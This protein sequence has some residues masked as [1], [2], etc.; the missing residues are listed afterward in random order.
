MDDELTSGP[1][2]A[3]QPVGSSAPA[4]RPRLGSEA[5]EDGADEGEADPFSQWSPGE[6]DLIPLLPRGTALFE[7]IPANA[8]VIDALCPAIGQGTVIVRAADCVGVVL[9]KDGTVFEEHAFESGTGLQGE[10][11][12]RAI[13]TWVDAGVAAY[14]LDPLVVAVIPSLFRGSPCYSDLRLEW[15][16]WP[17]LLADLCGRDGSFVVELDTPLGRGV[18]LIVDGRQVATYTESHTDLGPETLLDPLADTRRGTIW[19]RREPSQEAEPA[20]AGPATAAAVEGV[21]PAEPVDLAGTATAGTA[22][23]PEPAAWPAEAAWPAQVAEEL[24][25]TVSDQPPADPAGASGQAE[26]SPFAR[27]A[28]PRTELSAW[29]MPAGDAVHP[30]PPPAFADPSVADLAP[31][32]KQVARNHL[33]RSSSRVETM[34]DEA[35]ARELPLR[36]FLAEIRG[37]VIRGVMQSTLDDMADEM[38]TLASPLPPG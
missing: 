19:V 8:V 1:E 20:G 37:L 18:T 25:P 14:R 35:V 10:A 32:L 13:A 34:V 21:T 15:T 7:G 9:V 24:S 38:A 17:G 16:D 4:G 2:P 5:E 28:A 30:G 36:S 11:A 33:Q 26:E 3:E 27:F 22:A 6:H 23:Y 29:A 31:E 12:R